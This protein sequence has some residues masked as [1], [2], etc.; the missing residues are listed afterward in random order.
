MN[1]LRILLVEDDPGRAE[2]LLSLF[3]SAQHAAVSVPTVSEAAEALSLQKFDVALFSA[4]EPAKESTRFAAILRDSGTQENVDSRIAVFSCFPEEDN[5]LHSDGYL[6]Y[7]FVAADLEQ[8]FISLR[9]SIQ[10]GGVSRQAAP[11]HLATFEPAEFEEQCAHES[12][13][14]LEIIGLFFEEC[15]NELPEMREALAESDFERLLRL[16][17]T[18]KG[19][20]ASLQAPFARR[21]A[22]TLESAAKDHKFAI[23][24]ETLGALEQ[25]LGVLNR[26]LESFRDTCLCR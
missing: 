20:L 14:M 17:H 2:R 25:D 3:A 15:R 5:L 21:R 26:H 10:S 6:P 13:L 11:A 18:L 12:E 19:S 4:P 9:E 23:C 16:A 7:D 8:A 24:S 22:Q 1:N